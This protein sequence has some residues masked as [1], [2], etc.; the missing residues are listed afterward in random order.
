MDELDI[1]N[2]SRNRKQKR[3]PQP[4]FNE[5]QGQQRERQRQQQQQ[6][7]ERQPHQKKKKPS[8]PPSKNDDGSLYCH[9]D[10][11]LH[12]DDDD[13]DP[14]AAAA[15]HHRRLSESLRDLCSS[16]LR[17]VE[18]PGG[19]RRRRRVM[20]D[21]GAMLSA[22]SESLLVPSPDGVDRGGD[23]R[24]LDGDRDDDDEDG[25]AETTSM[26]G[27]AS[28][29][30]AA[31][32]AAAS[33]A[34]RQRAA[35]AY[36]PIPPPALLSFGSYRLG[37]HAPDADIDCLVLAPPHCTREDFFGGWVGALGRMV[38][39]GRISGL[40]PVK[41][42]VPSGRAA[43]FVPAAMMRSPPTHFRRMKFE[44]AVFHF[45]RQR[46]VFLTSNP[47][48]HHAFSRCPRIA[49]PRNPALTLPSSNLK[50][51]VSR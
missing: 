39:G 16:Q 18:S 17:L 8:L 12:D 28:T 47:I 36:G 19:M 10:D 30:K 51:M 27:A 3:R 6:H 24:A 23:P 40:H 11:D 22:W 46:L 35:A 4:P 41:R 15:W 29:E 7:Q 37:V 9:H 33:A 2:R 32:S 21:L 20:R 38:D 44:L 13:V 49:M 14:D 26:I 5:R 50:W 42:R 34:S 45:I 48:R 43:Y 31:A 25:N 1:H